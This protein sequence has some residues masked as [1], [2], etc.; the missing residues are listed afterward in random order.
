MR[1]SRAS[2]DDFWHV[3]R[4][5]GTPPVQAA[6]VAVFGSASGPLL[7]I[8]A[9]PGREFKRRGPRSPRKPVRS[10][11]GVRPTVGAEECIR[12]FWSGSVL[13]PVPGWR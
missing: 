4:G 12:R 3:Q 1:R 2:F 8:V 6:R 10:E 7:W 13:S 9:Q 5:H 11:C